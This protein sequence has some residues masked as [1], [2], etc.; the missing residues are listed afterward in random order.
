[1][2][3]SLLRRS[4]AFFSAVLLSAQ[5]LHAQ[6]PASLDTI[7]PSLMKRYDVPGLALAIVQGNKV[8]A[9]KG[10]GI[11]R[12][13]DGAAVDSAR[14]LFRLGSL[15]KLFIA[16]AVMQQLFPF[17][18][19]LDED[20]NSFLE[21]R[22]PKTWPEPVTL[23]RL[24][25]HSAGFDERI[26]G[27]AAPSRDSVGALGPYLRAN[28]PNRGWRPGEVIGYSNYGFALA[29][30]VVERMS[31]LPFDRYAQERIFMPLGMTRTFYVRAPNPFAGNLADGHECV[32]ASCTA[33]AEVYSRPYAVGLVYSTAADMAQFLVAQLNRGASRSGRALD[34]GAVTRMQEEHFTAD[35]LLPGMSYGFINQ[36]HRGHRVLSH[37]G[38][39]PGT[40][41]LLLLIPDVKLGVYFVANGGRST[42]G[43]AL[44][45]TLFAMLIPAAADAPV[46]P[47]APVGPATTPALSDE[48]L[49]TLAGPY[50]VTR[51]AHRT[52]ERFP[53]LFSTSVELG[54]DEGRL[55]LPMGDTRV[56]FAPIDSLHFR[57][58][59]GERLIAFRRD[60]SGAITHLIAP[61]PV[62]GSELTGTLERRAWHERAHFMNEYVSWLLLVPLLLIF[63]AWP[64]ATILARRRRLR[65]EPDAPH[66]RRLRAQ[67]ALA[68]AILFMIFWAFF[69]FDFIAASTRMIENANGI[70][71]GVPAEFR[72]LAF[73]PWV[74]AVLAFLMVV[75]AIAAWPARWWDVTRRTL[76]ALVTV[77]AVLTIVFLLR[78]NYL[79][80]VF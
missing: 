75:S 49:R 28:L 18:A 78:W 66:K 16:T 73:M 2:T 62:F 70:V 79:P 61:I 37:A 68:V 25:T 5:P 60:S 11:A 27:Y 46:A 38:T 45:D 69:G 36:R 65:T 56:A 31:G 52:I 59:G 42:F 19:E 48:Y 8:V 55:M 67:A 32:G 4:A 51:Y 13:S 15:G 12:A 17:Y 9:L 10:F 40:S 14:T 72:T 77:C 58:V 1:M 43:A 26:I 39:V 34:S 53:L 7:V 76:Y 50:Q 33:V 6:A 41:N 71:Y 57:E 35:S 64:I 29:A 80:P 3:S 30:H 24:L 23:E 22:I 21:F 47:V 74:L 54:L 63:V 44:R 20:V